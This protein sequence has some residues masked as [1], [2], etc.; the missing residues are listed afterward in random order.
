MLV[1]IIICTRV[2]Y[3]DISGIV[4]GPCI[5]HYIIDTSTAP[6]T[7]P[8]YH[9]HVSHANISSSTPIPSHHVDL[10]LKQE[11]SLQ[12]WV[13]SK[14]L[15]RLPTNCTGD[16][17]PQSLCWCQLDQIIAPISPSSFSEA[18]GGLSAVSGAVPGPHPTHAEGER[19][20]RCCR[21]WLKIC[22]TLWR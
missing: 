15:I 13:R 9:N 17:T 12:S 1:L 7:L 8:G 21:L 6:F 22:S 4:D 10:F 20:F 19:L 14:H 18:S 2:S 16:N 11:Q 3:A 5:T